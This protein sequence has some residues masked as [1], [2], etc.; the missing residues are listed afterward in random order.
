MTLQGKRAPIKSMEENLP[1]ASSIPDIYPFGSLENPICVNGI[2]GE[3]DYLQRLFTMAHAPLFFHRLGSI[4]KENSSLVDI[5][6]LIAQDSS[7]RWV[8]AMLHCDQT[9][10]EAPEGLWLAPIPLSKTS[11]ESPNTGTIGVDNFVKNFPIGLPRG[12]R[13]AWQSRFTPVSEYVESVL[14]QFTPEEW[15]TQSFQK[16]LASTSE[17]HRAPRTTELAKSF[18][19]IPQPRQ[20]V[21]LPFICR[22]G[23]EETSTRRHSFIDEGNWNFG[24]IEE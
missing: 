17:A 20:R 14:S 21:Y 2:S 16:I 18:V 8:L 13:K 24:P 22:C 12:F 10:D 5:Y 15:L 1:P 7:G 11:P 6:E 3:Y 4:T 19:A 23:C 9:S